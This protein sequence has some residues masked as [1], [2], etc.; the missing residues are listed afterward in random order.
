MTTP[1]VWVRSAQLGQYTMEE[2]QV[3]SSGIVDLRRPAVLSPA[4]YGNCEASHQAQS[5]QDILPEERECAA[6]RFRETSDIPFERPVTCAL[7]IRPQR[8]VRS[9][10]KVAKMGGAMERLFA[11]GDEA[12]TPSQFVA[13]LY[14]VLP[15]RLG[16]VADFGS[17]KELSNTGELRFKVW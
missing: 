4:L 5:C 17:R 7:E 1:A 15:F 8:S 13:S 14:E 3:V 16:E 6:S 11:S 2:R 10:Q 12:Q 9:L